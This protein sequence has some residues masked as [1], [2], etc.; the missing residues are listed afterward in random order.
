MRLV[1]FVRSIS[2][3]SYRPTYPFVSSRLPVSIECTIAPKGMKFRGGCRSRFCCTKTTRGDHVRG[4][5]AGGAN[6]VHRDNLLVKVPNTSFSIMNVGCP[7]THQTARLLSEEKLPT[8]S[9]SRAVS[10][11]SPVDVSLGSV[12]GEL[13]AIRSKYQVRSSE[14]KRLSPWLRPLVSS[15]LGPLAR[16]PLAAQRE[17]GCQHWCGIG[18]LHLISQFPVTVPHCSMPLVL[19]RL[20]LRTLQPA[21]AHTGLC[22]A[23]LSV[24]QE[25]Q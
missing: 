7:C 20:H 21:S 22:A 5:G 9:A 11:P 3:A 6:Q 23:N 8:F 4:E 1:N 18:A 17:A 14:M 12:V 15:L 25:K 16:C 13:H 2:R 10:M 24:L 19:Q